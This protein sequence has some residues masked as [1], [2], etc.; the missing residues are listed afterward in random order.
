MG[1]LF[2]IA[3]SLPGTIF[4]QIAVRQGEFGTVLG[5]VVGVLASNLF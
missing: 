2:L 1:A 3:S 4:A 5:I